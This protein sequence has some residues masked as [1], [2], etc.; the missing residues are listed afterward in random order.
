M[1]L[2]DGTLE[3]L[4][5]RGEFP[6]INSLAKSAFHQM[7]QALDCLAV[8][9]I[10]HRDVK[11]E[12][13]LYTALPDAR[14]R[15]YLGDFGLCN[16]T[17]IAQSFVGSPLY[18]A[19]EVYRHGVQTPK[20]D[21]W[22][23]FVTIAWT[24]DFDRFRQNLYLSTSLPQAYQAI[25]AMTSMIGEIHEMAR[26]DPEDRASAAQMLV[27]C[28]H[29]EG[30]STQ[31]NQVPP[32]TPSPRKPEIRTEV[33]PEPMAQVKYRPAQDIQ[34]SPKQH[35]N[36]F[37]VHKTSNPKARISGPNTIATKP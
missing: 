18:T 32:L 26:V 11:P 33:D 13:I 16:R 5:L 24:L 10:V 3:S 21:I 19:P 20:M 37:R 12:N 9:G 2:K 23:L 22:S 29:G 6:S 8:N 34:R 31:P 14:Y 15:F 17:V 4:V 25:L 35:T 27:K 28:F 30:L 7:L 1:G 36:R